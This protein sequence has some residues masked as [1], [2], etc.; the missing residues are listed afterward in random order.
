MYISGGSEQR[1]ACAVLDDVM[2]HLDTADLTER[3]RQCVKLSVRYTI[4]RMNTR[5]EIEFGK[6]T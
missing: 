1:L 3:E 6:M 5:V 2:A 4:E